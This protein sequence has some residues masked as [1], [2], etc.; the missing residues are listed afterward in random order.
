MGGVWSGFGVGVKDGRL[1][2]NILQWEKAPFLPFPQ[3]PP[4]EIYVST[5]SG[6]YH[7]IDHALVK[8][9]CSSYHDVILVA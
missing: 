5:L 4:P 6:D 7:Q 1:P 2:V 8:T 3:P 9:S